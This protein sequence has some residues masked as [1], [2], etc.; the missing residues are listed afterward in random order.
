[1]LQH[2]R[3]AVDF[4]LAAHHG[5]TNADEAD[6]FAIRIEVLPRFKAKLPGQGDP[7]AIDPAFDGADGGACNLCRLFVREALGSNEKQNFF[8]VVTQSAKGFLEINKIHV[9]LLIG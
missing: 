8:L 5:L 6:E 7:S 1:M 2:L 9:N 4:E 3:R